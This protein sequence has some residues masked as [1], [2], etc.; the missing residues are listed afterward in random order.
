MQRVM[1]I[2]EEYGAHQ[3]RVSGPYYLLIRL[4][5]LLKIQINTSS[6]VYA[7]ETMPNTAVGE[8]FSADTAGHMSS[9]LCGLLT[10]Q[11]SQSEQLFTRAL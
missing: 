2:R 11:G 10:R 6:I 1:Y 4:I 7:G 3:T 5:Y 8:N 9:H